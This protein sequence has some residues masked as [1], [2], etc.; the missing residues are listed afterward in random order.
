MQICAL[1]TRIQCKVY[2]AQVTVKVCGPLVVL[3]SWWRTKIKE[4]ENWKS[5]CLIVFCILLICMAYCIT[6]FHQFLCHFIIFD[7]F[8][9]YI[10]QSLEIGLMNLFLVYF[11]IFFHAFGKPWQIKFNWWISLGFFGVSPTACP[12]FTCLMNNINSK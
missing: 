8:S 4:I 3:W 7:F 6:S 12:F 10:N 5:I 2:D 9:R 1:L 11:L